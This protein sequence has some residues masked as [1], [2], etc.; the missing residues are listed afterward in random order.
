[1]FHRYRCGI[2]DDEKRIRDSVIEARKRRVIF[3]VGYGMASIS[4]EVAEPSVSQ[5]FY[6]DT[7]LHPK[8]ME[9]PDKFANIKGE[10]R[11]RGYGE[12]DMRRS[13]ERTGLRYLKRYSSRLP[14]HEWLRKVR[15]ESF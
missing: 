12:A 2:R 13:W 9:T 8:E 11:R 3:D 4:W 14:P 6:P 7:L 10:I 1:M 15:R 5:D